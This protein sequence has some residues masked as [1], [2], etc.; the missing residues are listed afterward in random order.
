MN[1]LGLFSAKATRDMALIPEHSN[2]VVASEV[3]PDHRDVNPVFKNSADA[4]EEMMNS[5]EKFDAKANYAHI[6]IS[7]ERKEEIDSTPLKDL[8]SGILNV[9]EALYATRNVDTLK[10]ADPMMM[11]NYE[12]GNELRN[13]ALSQIQDVS[14]L[15][16]LT[17]TLSHR[18]DN[19]PKIKDLGFEPSPKVSRSIEVMLHNFDER[20]EVSNH[21]LGFN[22]SDY[23]SPYLG[24][25][26][27]A[28]RNEAEDIVNDIIDSASIDESGN[29]LYNTLDIEPSRMAYLNNVNTHSLNLDALTT[30]EVLYK[31]Q[32][33]ELAVDLLI[34]DAVG[35]NSAEYTYDVKS[36]KSNYDDTYNDLRHDYLD[37]IGNVNPLVKNNNAYFEMLNEDAEKLDREIGYSVIP[38]S[39]ERQNTLDNTP[40][41]RLDLNNLTVAETLYATRDLSPIPPFDQGRGE[42]ELANSARQIAAEQIENVGSITDLVERSTEALNTTGL[43]L[44]L[45][46]RPGI[47]IE[48][49]SNEKSPNPR[50][51]ELTM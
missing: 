17:E 15:D 31:T 13:S 50:G 2:I 46:N 41:S 47:F 16:E 44:A 10:V 4:F 21:N 25:E 18:F 11:Q 45:Q 33:K 30:E 42:W 36:T 43:K 51:G 48:E 9:A 35:D 12:A 28:Y 26:Y 40:F 14:T 37:R 23:T 34:R 7:P 38:I 32:S 27:S 19:R 29:T 3:L 24:D 39:Q 22:R 1:D 8:N 20:N 6:P 5:P 49:P